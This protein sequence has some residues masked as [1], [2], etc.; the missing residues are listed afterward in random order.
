ML[1]FSP[2]RIAIVLALCAGCDDAPADDDE[3][4]ESDASTTDV[5]T[6]DYTTQIQPIWNAW[7]TCHLQGPSGE[8]EATTLTL[9]QEFSHDELVGRASTA[10]PGLARIEPGDPDASYLWH[11]IHDTHVEVGGS[12]TEM[13]PGQVLADADMDL[14]EHW[15]RGGAL[16]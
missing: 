12:G 9:N 8:M 3:S 13:P 4:S 2:S 14:I 6:V 10:V 16:P 15:I 7:C 5:P 1:R 11:K